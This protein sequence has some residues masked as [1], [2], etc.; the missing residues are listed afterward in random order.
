MRDAFVV[1][2]LSG[3]RWELA[4]ELLKDSGDH[5]RLGPLELSRPVHHGGDG[6]VHVAIDAVGGVHDERADA[7]VRRDLHLLS[8]LRASSAPL[9]RLI[10]EVGLVVEYVNDYDDGAVTLAVFEHGRLRWL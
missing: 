6:R 10:A 4:L 5:V 9:D 2:E 1:T 3:E 7:A 8:D